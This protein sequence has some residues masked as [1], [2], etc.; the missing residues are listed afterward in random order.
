MK[1]RRL[2]TRLFLLLLCVLLLLSVMGCGGTAATSS[3]VSDPTVPVP[4]VT[5]RDTPTQTA[6]P[7]ETTT[8]TT[9]G[10]GTTTTARA[11][12][13]TVSNS[14]EDVTTAK[15]TDSV[16]VDCDRHPTHWT[17][18]ETVLGKLR[19]K[20]VRFINPGESRDPQYSKVIADF[21]AKT[22]LTVDDVVYPGTNYA[23]YVA[24]DAAGGNTTDVVACNNHLFRLL[25]SV[26]P[27]P[28]I[29]DVTDGFWD[30]RVSEGSRIGNNM[31]FVNSYNT[32]MPSGYAVYYNKKIFHNN[33]IT[34]PED[35]LDMGQWTYENLLRCI[36]DAVDRGYKGGHVEPTVLP[37]QKGLGFINYNVTTG[38]C[39][40]CIGDEDFQRALLFGSSLTG[41][42]LGAELSA[43]IRG[44]V[45][46]CVTSL[47]G[48]LHN[49]HFKDMAADIGVVPLPTSYE[50]KTLPYA[51]GAYCGY[52]IGKRADQVE[53]AYYFL[54]YYLDLNMYETAGANIFANKVLEKYYRA[55][56]LPAMKRI[57]PY[58]EHYR[59][60]LDAVGSGWTSA[61]WTAV[62]H[63]VAQSQLVSEME[64]LREKVGLAAE[65]V[66]QWVKAMA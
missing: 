26:Q 16:R 61:A 48:L 64:K 56:H 18:N 15:R 45:G 39:T 13:S 12:S 7:L 27:L 43:F 54:R 37:G 24:M 29:F 36:E 42:R 28:K 52:G 11:D 25:Q 32:P 63:S 53:A 50:G 22:G 19:G 31:Y 55:T 59:E 40:I 66:N 62:R 30:P 41:K 58:Y 34:C 51:P 46:I 35:Y 9:A 2:R 23:S 3:L 47:G 60:A 5:L 33:G 20:T 4:S 49:G 1:T 10:K 6:P 44:E 8:A 38:K 65:Q 21:C 14:G 17:K 57:P